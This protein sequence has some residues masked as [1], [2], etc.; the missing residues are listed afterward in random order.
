M[1][2]NTTY[3]YNQLE[4]QEKIDYLDRKVIELKNNLSDFKRKKGEIQNFWYDPQAI[5]YV[6]LLDKSIK[7][8]NTAIYNTT[9]T[10]T[11]L[12]NIVKHMGEVK[13]KAENEIEESD[14]LV[15]KL[16]QIEDI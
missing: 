14:A 9:V 16:E 13:T 8:C 10:S 4:Y 2:D 12:K 3:K 7:A 1:A 11:E 6:Q 5:K 15:S